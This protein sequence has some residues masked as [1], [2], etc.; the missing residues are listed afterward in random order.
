MWL[1]HNCQAQS[2]SSFISDIIPSCK[3]CKGYELMVTRKLLRVDNSIYLCCS[4]SAIT[5]DA[6]DDINMA[7]TVNTV[8]VQIFEGCKF[9]GFRG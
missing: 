8:Y 9:R 6:A 1:S 3:S 7:L 4:T 2:Y 5:N